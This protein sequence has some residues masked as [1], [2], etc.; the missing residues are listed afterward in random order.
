MKRSTRRG[1]LA[2]LAALFAAAALSHAPRAEAD[3]VAPIP[4]QRFRFTVQR[5]LDRDAVQALHRLPTEDAPERFFRPVQGRA[6]VL[7]LSPDGMHAE[8]QRPGQPTLRGHMQSARRGTVWRYDLD[9]GAFA[10]GVLVLSL[11]PANFTGSLVV[12]G[13]G[14]PVVS[15]ERGPLTPAP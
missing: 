1:A 10:G 3:R 13:S 7:V 6:Y 14:V 12:R 9:E 4:V 15:I 2:A 5:E 11:D 8:V